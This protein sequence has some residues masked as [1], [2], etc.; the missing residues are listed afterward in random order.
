M[1]FIQTNIVIYVRNTVI[2]ISIA[3]TVKE[4]D[5]GTIMHKFVY[6]LQK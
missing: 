6:V 2:I 4:S 5:I 1:K 3:V